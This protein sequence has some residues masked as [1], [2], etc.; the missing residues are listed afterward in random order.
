MS[1][2]YIGEIRMFGGNFAPVGWSFCNGQL[3]AI[4][5]YEALFQL[6]GTTY[7]GNGV[8]TFAL[9]DLQGR[10]PMHQGRSNPLG[11]SAGTESVTLLTTQIP[12]HTHAFLAVPADPEGGSPSGT[13]LAQGSGVNIYAPA[14]PA[15]ANVMNPGVIGLSGGSQPHDNMQPYQ[16]VTFII[17]LEGIY[18]SQG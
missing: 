17:A 12:S 13:P 10:I 6:I 11:Q 15:K 14:N 4:S 16:C 9:P 8:Q 1:D 3:L 5:E 7:G 2:P 18:P